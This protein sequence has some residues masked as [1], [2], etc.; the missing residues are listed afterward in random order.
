MVLLYCVHG[1]RRT[2]RGDQSWKEIELV[3]VMNRRQINSI[4]LVAI[5]DLQLYF[6][7]ASPVDVAIYTQNKLQQ[8]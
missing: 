3:R 1:Q 5:I 8:Q 7:G 4:E 6:A 2:G